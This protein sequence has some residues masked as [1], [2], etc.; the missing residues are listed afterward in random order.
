MFENYNFEPKL[1]ALSQ[2]LKAI[3][4]LS[5]LTH[6]HGSLQGS[7]SAAVPSKSAFPAFI[8]LLLPLAGLWS[9]AQLTT[10]KADYAPGSTATITGTGFM[11][12]E[13]VVMQVLHADGIPNTGHGHEA[14]F[15]DADIDGNFETTWHVCEDDCVGSTLVAKGVGQMSGLRA[16]VY[17]TDSGSFGYTTTT[18]KANTVSLSAGASNSTTLGTNVTSPQNNGTFNAHLEFSTTAGTSIGIGTGNNQIDLSSVIRQ[19]QTGGGTTGMP[20]TE[21]TKSFPITLSVGASVAPG[22]YQFR[23]RAIA[24]GVAEAAGW[25]FSVVVTGQ[26]ISGITVH[27]QSGTAE[28]G[29]ASIVTYAIT[30]TRGA[31]GDVNGTY[32]AVGLP[33]GVTPAFN[34]A[35]FT[36][37][38]TAG[39][40]GTTL[41]LAISSSV[42][43]GS[44]PFDVILSDGTIQVKQPAT[45]LVSDTK[46]PNLPVLSTITVE[47]SVT[48][49]APKTNDDCAG[50]ITGTTSDPLSYSEQGEF[51]IHW[52]FD[53]GN[54][55][56]STQSQTV[57]VKDTKA[58]EPD[59]ATLPTVDAV[60]LAV[61]S[62][63]KATD[64]CIGTVYGKGSATEFYSPGTY[65]VVWTYS[66]GHGNS[67]E[68]H[69]TVIVRSVSVDAGLSSTPTPY[70]VAV[71]LRAKIYPEVSG[72][73]VEFFVNGVSV[74]KDATDN[75]GMAELNI[76]N[77]TVG[78]YQIVAEAMYGCGT[79]SA[80]YLPVY[81]PNG[82]FVTGGGWIQSPEGAYVASPSASGKANFGFV[83]KYKKGSNQVEGNTEFQ[84]TAGNLNFKSASHNAGT[85]VIAGPQA[86]YKGVGTINSAGNYGFMVS[87]VDGVVNGGGG[88][89]K[90]RIKIWD[91]SNG[92]AI[93]YDN[94]LG[95][96]ENALA[97]T[98]L[99][100]GSIVIHE[101]KGGG[102]KTALSQSTVDNNQQ[103]P[104][105]SVAPNPSS[106]FFRIDLRAD[107]SNEKIRI[108]IMD[109]TGRVLE[110]RNGMAGGETLY[111]GHT[112]APGVYF[113][114]LLRANNQRTFRLIKQTY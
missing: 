25:P 84:F 19:F 16:D 85:L 30:A 65:D 106:D 6:A 29:T 93:V 51:T 58:P 100:G 80:V 35:S 63:P 45:L 4:G 5:P 87:A 74:G 38:G 90:F 11:S 46:A 111:F 89:D 114:Q 97:T 82:G 83:A 77:K 91:I 49:S 52:T 24:D 60:C 10:D 69:Q 43:K 50:E 76:G 56:M 68:Q 31:A 64:N 110:E 66:D 47:C 96:N 57:E 18:G 1:N 99:G 17:F 9:Q 27:P 20:R 39:L 71:V 113:A 108:R 62:A 28:C 14:W 53:D 112:Y 73:V 109:A 2:G 21:D 94:Q 34:P 41:E 3:L 95:A 36:S 103:L 37:S 101:P 55:N 33:S 48:V 54:G 107:D 26:K 92:D 98:A 8:F 102:G 72:I 61:L 44:Y 105:I 88:T 59:V 23:A 81:D 42:S 70:N 32:S 40:S 78:V 7:R 104:A 12:G 22:T 15:V 75:N 79:S 67:S 13:P 86:I